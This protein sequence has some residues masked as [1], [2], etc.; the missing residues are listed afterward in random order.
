MTPEQLHHHVCDNGRWSERQNESKKERKK[1]RKK[2]WIAEKRKSSWRLQENR[3]SERREIKEEEE[4][5]K[6]REM[7]RE[8]EWGRGREETADGA[9]PVVSG[10]APDSS[11]FFSDLSLFPPREEWYECIIIYHMSAADCCTVH[12]PPSSCIVSFTSNRFWE[13]L[14]LSTR[15]SSSAQ[16][17]LTKLCLLPPFLTT[18]RCYVDHRFAHFTTGPHIICDIMFTVRFLHEFLGTFPAEFV[19]PKHFFLPLVPTERLV[20]IRPCDESCD[21]VK[22]L[23]WVKLDITSHNHMMSTT[24]WQEK[25]WTLNIK[26]HKVWTSLVQQ[27]GLEH[28]E[29]KIHVKGFCS[30]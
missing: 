17:Q 14:S 29:N 27:R 26:K 4:E 8:W 11:H 23:K 7:W 6:K 13:P 15:M 18:W 20:I 24:L 22:Q 19:G 9:G 5:K 25:N 12:Q 2:D 10:A 28:Q 3:K 21:K 30:V 1:E 16:V